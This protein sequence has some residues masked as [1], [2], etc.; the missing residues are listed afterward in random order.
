MT[1]GNRTRYLCRIH[2][3]ARPGL[4]EWRTHPRGTKLLSVVMVASE[5]DDAACKLARELAES[6]SRYDAADGGTGV[7]VV[8]VLALDLAIEWLSELGEEGC[9]RVVATWDVGG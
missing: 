5:N 2:D 8:T 1:D 7:G 4:F 6:W 3:D 9:W